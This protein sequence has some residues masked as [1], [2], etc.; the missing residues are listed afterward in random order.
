[1]IGPS[2]VVLFVILIVATFLT[3]VNRL[4]RSDEHWNQGSVPVPPAKTNSTPAASRGRF[5]H[6]EA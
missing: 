2:I 4:L 1:M 6:A 5:V 3:I